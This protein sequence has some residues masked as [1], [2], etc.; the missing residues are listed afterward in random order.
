VNYSSEFG[1]I[2]FLEHLF[3][4]AKVWSLTDSVTTLEVLY[5][6]EQSG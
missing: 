4:T 6:E 5:E 3:L 2:A 1:Y